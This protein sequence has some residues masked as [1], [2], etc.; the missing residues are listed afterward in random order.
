MSN[1]LFTWLDGD[2]SKRPIKLRKIGGA[3]IGVQD[4]PTTGPYFGA[5]SF[6]VDLEGG[7]S[8]SS[9]LGSYYERLPNGKNSLFGASGV[10]EL[11]ELKVFTGVYAK[12]EPIPFD[13]VIVLSLT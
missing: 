2:T 7:K 8:A 10:A 3:G 5:D 13:D 1:F 11:R 4:R 12:G 6:C 9:K